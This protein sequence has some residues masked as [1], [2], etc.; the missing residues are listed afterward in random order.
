M[1]VVAPPYRQFRHQSLAR[2]S[3]ESIDGAIFIMITVH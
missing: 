3:A 1:D 2:K